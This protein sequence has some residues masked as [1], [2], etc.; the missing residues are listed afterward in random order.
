MKRKTETEV[1][2]KV[3]ITYE[4]ID[5]ARTP[6]GAWTA[7]QLNVLGVSWPPRHGWRQR[8]IGTWISAADA[9]RFKD[10][11]KK[12]KPPKNLATKTTLKLA[13][14]DYVTAAYAVALERARNGDEHAGM[15]A[16]DLEKAIAI[17]RSA[18]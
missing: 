7:Q 1:A 16:D 17:M 5:G 11:G 14:L 18:T 3:Q 2:E 10:L 6:R 12:G 13:A 9:Q 4:L 8:L 15:I